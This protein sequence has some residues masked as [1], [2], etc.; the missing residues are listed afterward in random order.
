MASPAR[1]DAEAAFGVLPFKRWIPFAMATGND[2]ARDFQQDAERRAFI[3]AMTTLWFNPALRLQAE[4]YVSGLY[5]ATKRGSAGHQDEGLRFACAPPT[6]GAV[7]LDWVASFVPAFT[8]LSIEDVSVIKAWNSRAPQQLFLFAM[9]ADRSTQLPEECIQHRVLKTACMRR[10]ESVGN[11][12]ADLRMDGVRISA[13]GKINT[14]LV[15]EFHFGRCSEEEVLKSVRHVFSNTEIDVTQENICGLYEIK[16]NLSPGQCKLKHGARTITVRELFNRDALLGCTKKMTGK[17]AVMART[18]REALQQLVAVKQEV[19][20][21]D[22]HVDPDA[23]M[24]ATKAKQKEQMEK[25]REKL[26]EQQ[27][28]NRKRKAVKVATV[29]P[30]KAPKSEGEEKKPPTGAALAMC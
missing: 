2:E 21:A 16:G 11:V 15:G 26:L 10:I 13:D 14:G 30:V 22:V 28:L 1:F 6:L 19:T 25:A 20:A 29:T 23:V 5:L 7:D 24:Q 9:W 3:S 8:Q 18:V 17:D 27:E 4:T 12:L